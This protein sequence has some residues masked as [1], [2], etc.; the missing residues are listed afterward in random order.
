MAGQNGLNV[1]SNQA[2][3]YGQAP[4]GSTGTAAGVLRTF[5]LL[6]SSVS[7]GLAY[8]PP[9]RQLRRW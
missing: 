7:Y 6:C 8:Q 9:A 4:A 1:V 3:M 2:A 5:L